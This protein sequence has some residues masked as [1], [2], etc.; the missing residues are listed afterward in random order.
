MGT[1]DAIVGAGSEGEIVAVDAAFW[2][3]FDLHFVEFFGERTAI[4][5]GKF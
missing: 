2:G 4:A 1:K 3:A 5:G